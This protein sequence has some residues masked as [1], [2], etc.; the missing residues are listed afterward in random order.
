MFLGIDL[1]TGSIKTLLVD[2]GG[3]TIGRGSVSCPPGSPSAGR[4]EADP[5][6]WWHAL[7]IAARQALGGNRSPVRAIGLS[8]QMHGLVGIDDQHLVVHPAI[9]WPDV[10]AVRELESFSALPGAMLDR[11]ANPLAVGMA[12]P[13]LLWLSAHRPDVVSRAR[14]WMQPKDWLRSRLTGRIAGEHSDASATLLYDVYAQE[15]ATDVTSALGLDPDQLP[16]LIESTALA[17]QLTEEAASHL[18]L[19]VGVPVA[20]GGADAACSQFG[21]GALPTGWAHLTVGSGA[22]ITISRSRPVGDSTRRTHLY[23][24]VERDRWYAMAA[25]QNIG[26]ALDWVRRLLGADWTE[27]YG[28]LSLSPPGANG[29]LFLPYLSAERTPH[30]DATATG[31]WVGLHANADRADVL[32]AAVEG[33]V[34]SIRDGLDA[35]QSTGAAIDVLRIAGGGS[36]DPRMRQLLADVLDRPL[37]SSGAIDA[38]AFG[39]CR[40]AAR[41]IGDELAPPDVDYR[42]VSEPRAQDGEFDAQ[43]ARFRATYQ[44]QRQD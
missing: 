34:L 40:L 12:G 43:L 24:S 30:V 3:V 14:W 33:C 10:R 39:A 7:G 23:R 35:L 11:L 15:W 25:M 28:S 17:G 26:L 22:T 41:S 13:S 19:P 36:V 27:V 29:V 5:A 4:S 2:G 31:S 6:A 32:R 18:G 37:A 38:S 44:R 42:I 21:F 8:G 16:P 9:L 1:G 20:A